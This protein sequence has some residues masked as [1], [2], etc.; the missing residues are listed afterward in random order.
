MGE[1]EER[2]EKVAKVFIVGL[3]L[4]VIVLIAL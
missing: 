2:D 1:V 4:F 3:I